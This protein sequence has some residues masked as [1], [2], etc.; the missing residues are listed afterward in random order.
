M[1]SELI[2]ALKS[3]DEVAFRKIYENNFSGL[4]RFANSYLHNESISEDIVQNAFML[5][6]EKK[7]SLLEGTNIKAFLVTIVKTKTLN[8]LEK[9][10]THLKIEQNLHELRLKEINLDVY[11]LGSL[12]PEELFTSELEHLVEES[13]QSLP[14]R[15]RTV[16]IMSRR[17]GLSNQD[18]ASKLEISV[19]GVE[20]HITKALKILRK[21][22]GDYLPILIFFLGK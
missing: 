8:Y 3:G 17:E 5:L 11:T 4:H 16:F 1:S 13:I 9:E 12:N 14:E 22:L 6:W 15:T 2:T 21:D 10:Q 7:A 20:F 18:I 19:K